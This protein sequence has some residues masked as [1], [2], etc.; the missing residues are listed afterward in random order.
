MSSPALT[1]NRTSKVFATELQKKENAA[2]N[3]HS[4][5]KEG[6]EATN[7]THLSDCIQMNR[8]MGNRP[9]WWSSLS[10]A[11]H[12]GK[13]CKAGEMLCAKNVAV[14]IFYYSFYYKIYIYRYKII[15]IGFP[16]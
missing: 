6:E 7:P 16:M 15:R 13:F 4:V 10:N 8:K 3:I 9:P 14:S 11:Q 12:S 1:N 2:K 5:V